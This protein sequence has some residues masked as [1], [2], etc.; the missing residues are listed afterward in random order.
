[1]IV[2]LS[3]N[4]SKLLYLVAILDIT[5]ANFLVNFG[6]HAWDWAMKTRMVKSQPFCPNPCSLW[7]SNT[8]PPI[9]F[10]LILHTDDIHIFLTISFALRYHWCALRYHWCALR[11]Y[12]QTMTQNSVLSIFKFLFIF[13]TAFV[14]TTIYN[15]NY[16]VITIFGSLW[17]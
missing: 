12:G 13:K 6:V 14:P 17:H 8:I 11:N 3:L 10:C 1:M 9:S 4:H 5:P 16:L 15:M 7:C 2:P